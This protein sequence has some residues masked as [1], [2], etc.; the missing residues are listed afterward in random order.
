MQKVPAWLGALAI[1]LM[2][3]CSGS[4]MTPEEST[5]VSNAA[6]RGNEGAQL[7][8][9]FEYLHGDEG[10]T[11]D[12]KQAAYWFE[13]AG[14][15]GNAVAQKMLGDL[16]EQG[17]GVPQNF[18]LSADWRKKA[19]ERGNT[20]AQL[21]LGKMYLTG[22][23]VEKNRELADYWLNRAA[24]E[25]NSEAQYL[26]GKRY[27]F[28]AGN[29]EEQKKADDLLSSS[30]ARGYDSAVAFIHFMEDAGY[31]IAESFHQHG[32]DIHKLAQDGDANS[33]YQLAT[34]YES[35][36]LEKKNYRLALYWFGK[37]ADNG[38]IMAMKSL[39]HIY[40][41]GLDGVQAD[42]AAAQ[43]WA[44]RARAAPNAPPARLQH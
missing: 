32:A 35:G 24:I 41:K 11:R 22:L 34:R 16:Y 10:R 40:A 13:R 44:E 30:A 33:Q 19:A 17:H 2:F 4:A 36:H 15:Q 38:N 39:A 20:D 31:G 26:L 14:S 9:A 23:G 43:S 18:I 37:A 3:P 12:E 7:M 6:E 8:L 27:R 1:V 29:A 5:M 25:G 28:H 21:A 42:Q